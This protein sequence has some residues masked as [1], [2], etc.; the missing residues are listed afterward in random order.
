MDCWEFMGCPGDV[1]RACPAYPDRGLDC[2]KVTG[3]NCA[4]GRYVKASVMEK[5]EHC[6]SCDFYQKFAN[7]F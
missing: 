1:K 4:Q 3:T 2:W 6:R 7:K 5:I